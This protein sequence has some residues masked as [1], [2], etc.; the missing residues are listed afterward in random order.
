MN[1]ADKLDTSIRQK[2]PSK[3]KSCI[4]HRTADVK[5]HDALITALS[6]NELYEQ[7]KMDTY[8]KQRS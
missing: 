4:I 5:L 2:L 3:Y 7:L 6:H 1:I 8:E